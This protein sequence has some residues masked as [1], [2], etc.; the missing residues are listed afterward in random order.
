MSSTTPETGPSV[1][2]V[3]EGVP[4]VNFYRGGPRSPEDDPFPACLRAYL[5]YRGDDLG[6]RARTG[7]ADAWHEVHVYAMGM[8]GAAFRMTWDPKQ[9]NMGATDLLASS[10]NPFDGLRRAFRAAGYDCEIVLKRDFAQSHGQKQEHDYSEADFR[11]LIVESI[12]DRGRPVLAFGVIGPPE[13]GLITGYDEGGDVLIGWD[14]FQDEAWC[15]GG[16]EFEP[17]GYYRKRN[18]FAGTRG[19][20]LIGDSCERPA[21]REVNREALCA[22]L[23]LMRTPSAQGLLQGQAALTVWADTL[24]RDALFPAAGPS[25]PNGPAQHGATA[26][27]TLLEERYQV[28]H[29]TAGTLAEARAWGAWFLRLISDEEPGVAG[30]LHAAADCFD[31][32]HDL[33]WAIWEFTRADRSGHISS[34]GGAHRFAESTT[35]GRIVPLIRLIRKED[36][37]AARHLENALRQM[38]AEAG[39]HADANTNMNTPGRLGRA[40][41][42]NVPRIGYDVHTCPF[43]QRVARAA[44]LHRRP[45]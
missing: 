30:E 25:V 43:P 9:W 21:T 37:E 3:L 24:L 19:L 7:K 39:A 14:F 20:I 2:A 12:R 32:E 26:V 16:M 34:G 44:R 4:R 33:V 27:P 29:G 31:N 18:W 11:K 13:C 17:S 1:R 40:V 5:E 8:S 41:L 36:A 45:V 35:R 42:D 15:N 6:F 28:H 22:A 38:D 10:A 23:E